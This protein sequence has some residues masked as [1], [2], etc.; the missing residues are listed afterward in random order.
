MGTLTNTLELSIQRR[1]TKALINAD[2]TSIVL[3][4][5]A[6]SM[7]NGTLKFTPGSA[8]NPQNFKVIWDG[9]NGIA[10]ETGSPGEARRFDFILVGEHTATVA[11]G[12]VWKLGEQKFVIEFVEPSNGWEVKAG[13]ISHGSIP[14]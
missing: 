1:A 14:T 11:I 3:F 13:G 2:P 6:G 7:V 8:R 4:P 9:S 12:D 10:R 5:N